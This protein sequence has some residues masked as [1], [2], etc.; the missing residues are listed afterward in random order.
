MLFSFT[1][2]AT[3]C[4]DSRPQS[5]FR[6]LLYFKNEV[7]VFVFPAE[8]C[9]AVFFLHPAGGS[10]RSLSPLLSLA[11]LAL[12][13]RA[14]S[15]F[16]PLAL[17]SCWSVRESYYPCT[18]GPKAFNQTT[19]FYLWTPVFCFSHKH[20]EE[21]YTPITPEKFSSILTE[22][23]GFIRRRIKFSNGRLR[24]KKKVKTF[25]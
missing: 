24:T 21:F 18:S 10:L 6:S 23:A 8:Q 17:P 1:R 19:D 5:P 3:K 11:Q 4:L 2:Q 15:P 14:P 20:R 7:Y 16:S 25:F 12:F 22:I 9:S 13:R